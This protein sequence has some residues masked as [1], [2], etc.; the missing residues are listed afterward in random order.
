[1]SDRSVV[2]PAPGQIDRRLLAFDSPAL[3]GYEWPYFAA[4]GAGDGPTLC[5]IAGIHG[6][7]YPPIEAVIRFCRQLDPA[8]LRG[9]L[10]AL[11]VVNLPAFWERTPFVCPRDGKN[12][13]R[14]FPGDA[15]GTFS[16]ALAHHLFETVIRRG[17]YLVDLHCGDM[18][19]DLMPFSLAQRSGNA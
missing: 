10:V 14:V 9:R 3:A 5:L 8:K 15:N 16:E 4:S 2:F 18:V 12:P 11:P 13:N 7:E 17:E 1:M 19:E 6:A